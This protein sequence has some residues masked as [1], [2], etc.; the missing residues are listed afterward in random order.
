VQAP[1]CTWESG[2]L[3][4]AR[5]PAEPLDLAASRK[6]ELRDA[7]ETFEKQFEGTEDYS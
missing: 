5:T 6:P 7:S 1:A 3:E 2:K 4:L